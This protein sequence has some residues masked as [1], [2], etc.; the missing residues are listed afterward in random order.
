ML[1]TDEGDVGANAN[2]LSHLATPLFPLVSLSASTTTSSSPE[3]AH[4]RPHVSQLPTVSLVLAWP[5]FTFFLTPCQILCLFLFLFAPT[6]PPIQR[7]RHNRIE[8]GWRE[9]KKSRVSIFTHKCQEPEMPFLPLRS[10]IARLL[11]RRQFPSP[12]D[13]Q[14]PMKRLTV[15]YQDG[16]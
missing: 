2:Y 1:E 16:W 15:K 5:Q 3:T 12:V 6:F 13:K 14:K 7:R 9:R 4:W 11:Y 10:E 8:K